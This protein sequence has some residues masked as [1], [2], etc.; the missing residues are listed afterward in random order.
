MLP[1]TVAKP[2]TH[3]QD[4]GVKNRTTI[5]DVTRLSNKYKLV[6]YR[7]A[8]CYNSNL[9]PVQMLCFCCPELNSG[10]KF[11]KSTAEARHLNQ[12]CGLCSVLN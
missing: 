9:G 2:Q 5:F 1:F 11:N 10:I 3:W 6:F 4:R 12:T 7:L 8:E